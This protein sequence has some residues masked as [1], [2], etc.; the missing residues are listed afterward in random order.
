MNGLL[1]KVEK[2]ERV[3]ES[4]YFDT[5]TPYHLFLQLDGSFFRA[6]A[7]SNVR[8]K[9][10][11]QAAFSYDG[12]LETLQEIFDKTDFLKRPYTKVRCMVSSQ[13][14][15]LIPIMNGVSLDPE[16]ALGFN[17]NLSFNH[18]C[19]TNTI[20]GVDALLSFAMQKEIVAV[21]KNRFPQ[22]EFIHSAASTISYSLELAKNHTEPMLHLILHEGALELCLIN[23]GKLFLY[24]TFTYQ[25]LEDLVYYPLFIAEQFNLNPTQLYLN[26]SGNV[27]PNSPEF[28]MIKKYFSVVHLA[29]LDIRS[30]YAIRMEE[31]LI[32]PPF[33]TLFT[34]R[35]CE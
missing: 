7:Y 35:L 14:H 11:M 15:T 18:V 24:N 9:F 2:A 28:E 26:L 3:D 17:V 27:F 25:T 12:K 34:A 22:V 31:E 30:K 33:L 6:V 5:K 19:L 32:Y 1:H 23:N 21:V 10:V 20:K 4:F 13:E 29:P 8:E 16:T